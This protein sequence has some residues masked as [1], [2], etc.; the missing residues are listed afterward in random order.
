MLARPE[1]EQLAQR[2]I[3]RY[4]LD[5]LTPAETAQY[6]QHRLEVAGLTRPLPFERTALQRVHQL[7]RGVPRRV[8]LLCDRALLGAF[9]SGQADGGPR[10]GR[11]R[12]PPKC[13][14]RRR[15]R[16]ARWRAGR[17]R[18]WGWGWRPGPA[19][20]AMANRLLEDEPS[21]RTAAVQAAATAPP[22]GSGGLAC[23]GSWSSAA[24]PS[25]AAASSTSSRTRHCCAMPTRPGANWPEPGRSTSASR[26]SL[27]GVA[28]GASAL[29]QQEPQSGI[30]PRTGAPR[31]PDAGCR[32]RR[33]EL[34]RSHRP[35]PR[36]CHAARGRHRAEGDAGGAGGALAGRAS[37]RCG[38]RRRATPAGRRPD[39]ETIDWMAGAPGCCRTD[40]RRRPAGAHSTL[41]S[42]PSC[43]PS[44]WRRAWRPTAS[45]AP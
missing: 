39:G 37:P 31:H 7:A 23:D 15:L 16:R 19:L 6:V 26:R 20:F 1:L 18:C 14:G 11:T 27:Q 3:A 9:A 29:L 24:A 8:N 25:A 5:A 17:P 44:S 34:C 41:R 35:H 33:A 36:Q 22:S 4:H 10:D 43:G 42:S 12:P 2:V 28:E 38:R 30:D 13:S 40:C 21:R 32:Q 45:R